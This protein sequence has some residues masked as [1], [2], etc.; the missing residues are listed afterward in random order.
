M[1][2]PILFSSAKVLITLVF[3][4]LTKREYNWEIPD[5]LEV[6]MMITAIYFS[7]Y[8][9]QHNFD[10]NENVKPFV[11]DNTEFQIYMANTLY[12]HWTYLNLDM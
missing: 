3:T 12:L 2:L 4:A 8:Y 6:G 9:N 5:V 10:L 7:V 1:I 11:K